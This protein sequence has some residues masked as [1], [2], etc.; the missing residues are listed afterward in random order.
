MPLGS[1][2]SVGDQR[3]LVFCTKP[4]RPRGEKWL[5]RG[6]AQ[7]EQARRLRLAA[8]TGPPSQWQ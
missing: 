2:L 8:Q 3:G 5:E 1:F 6:G 4:F 7:V